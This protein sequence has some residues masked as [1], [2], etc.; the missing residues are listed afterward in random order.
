PAGLGAVPQ[1]R[2]QDIKTEIRFFNDCLNAVRTDIS[3]LKL[4]LKGQ[5]RP[6]ERELFDAYLHM[7]SDNALGSEVVAL[8][9]E[10]NWAQ[11]ALAHVA[12]SHV[13]NMALI[14]DD[15]LRERATD[16]NDL[17]SRVLCHPLELHKHSTY[18]P[19]R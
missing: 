5:L 13:S 14:V 19:A 15:Y 4:K 8:I 7:L 2:C 9:K 11:G 6:E 1:R 17:C 16:I 18:Q 10:G 12:L 3:E